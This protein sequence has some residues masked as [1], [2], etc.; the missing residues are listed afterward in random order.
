MLEIF[1][2]PALIMILVIAILVVVVTLIPIFELINLKKSKPKP[3]PENENESEPIEP[4]MVKHTSKSSVL[5]EVEFI[6]EWLAKLVIFVAICVGLTY[7]I[8]ML[9]GP[10]FEATSTLFVEISSNE[11]KTAVSDVLTASS[12]VASN[13]A[14]VVKKG[15]VVDEVIKSSTTK[16][17]TRKQLTSNLRANTI[18]DTQLIEISVQNTDASEAQRLANIFAYTTIE[19]YKD[20]LDEMNG[21]SYAQVKVIQQAE[22]PTETTFPSIK[23]AIILSTILGTIIGI[24]ALLVIDLEKKAKIKIV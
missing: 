14:E 1:S 10:K 23:Q 21:G 6:F 5:L 19:K 4:L 22:L 15:E 17:Y 12:K 8:V 16:T 24:G 18:R 2:S 7:M 3:L 13:I 11:N 20:L 9:L